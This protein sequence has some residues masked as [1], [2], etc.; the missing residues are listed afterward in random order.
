MTCLPCQ[1]QHRMISLNTKCIAISA[2]WAKRWEKGQ[3]YKTDTTQDLRTKQF[4]IKS[5][6]HLPKEKETKEKNK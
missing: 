1:N 4:T 3:I 6:T 2:K 5:F